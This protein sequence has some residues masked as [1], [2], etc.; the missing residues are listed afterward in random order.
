MSMAA[1]SEAQPLAA[2]MG[3]IAAAGGV[4]VGVHTLIAL[5]A[6]GGNLGPWVLDRA[7][8]GVARDN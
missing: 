5:M 4:G 2:V 8:R 3:T 6:A 1:T 7:E